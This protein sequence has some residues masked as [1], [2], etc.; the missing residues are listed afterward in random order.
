MTYD[1]EDHS[2]A[3]LLAR[4]DPKVSQKAF[5]AAKYSTSL[6]TF[7]DSLTFVTNPLSE[8]RSRGS[9]DLEGI[10]FDPPERVWTGNHSREAQKSEVERLVHSSTAG[11]DPQTNKDG[12]IGTAWP[13]PSFSTNFYEIPSS[14][15]LRRASSR[16]SDLADDPDDRYHTKIHYKSILWCVIAVQFPYEI[17]VALAV[18][19]VFGSHKSSTASFFLYSF[20][21]AAFFGI[22]IGVWQRMK[23]I[24][25]QSRM[26]S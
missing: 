12:R 26:A 16:P 24:K 21:V 22:A 10:E 18:A 25:R 3:N 20:G 5:D 2:T 6:K 4:K 15:Q 17:M 11:Y 13:A 7:L 1:A 19:G 8:S 9:I 23:E 14:Q